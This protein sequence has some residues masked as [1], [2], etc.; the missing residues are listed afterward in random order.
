MNETA[1]GHILAGRRKNLTVET[2]ALLART[3]QARPELVLHDT[4]PDGN[5]MPS[6]RKDE[7]VL[8]FPA[9]QA[10]QHN[11]HT[12]SSA[13]DQIQ[14]GFSPSDLQKTPASAEKV[15]YAQPELDEEAS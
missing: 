5:R 6:H 1:I 8:S 2:I 14:R 10:D 13:F 4:R 11:A 3:L 9:R 15:A 7:G 12:V